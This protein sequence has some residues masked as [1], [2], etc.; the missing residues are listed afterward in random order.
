MPIVPTNILP[1]D[2]V[3]KEIAKIKDNDLMGKGRSRNYVYME[4]I[5][6]GLEQWKKKNKKS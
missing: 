6:I 3:K 4:L 1:S 5:E 2:D